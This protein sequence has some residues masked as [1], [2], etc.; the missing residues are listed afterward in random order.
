MAD[1]KFYTRKGPFTLKEICKVTGAT[2]SDS[3]KDSL[4]IH[5]ITTLQSANSS[6]IAVF[7]NRKYLDSFSTSQAAACFVEEGSVHKAPSTMVCLVTPKPYR[8]YAK[9]LGMFY[10]E[11]SFTPSISEYAF[12]DPSATI[13]KNCLIEP[14]V[15]IRANVTIGNDTKILAHAVINEGVQIGNNCHIDVN[16]YVSHAQVGNNVKI[17]PH[18]TIGKTGFGFDMDQDGFISVPQIGRVII[19]DSVEI[20]ANCNIDRGSLEDT[21]IGAGS[22]IDSLVQLGHNVRLGKGCII[23][24]QVGIAGSTQLGNY[25]VAAGQVGIAGHLKIGDGVRIGAKSGLMRDVPA[26]ET[27]MGIPAVSFKQWQ[28]QIVT[29][30]R[31]VKG[32]KKIVKEE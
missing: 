31:L 23:V 22:R 28:K 18:S 10:S 12:I 4:M 14:G 26:G 13:G 20:G 2:L 3:T 11:A 7:H 30:E 29:L 8:A 24:S 15:V 19:E 27:V 32:R 21:I 16:V 9:V 1:S 25:V 6:T 5:D 17:Y